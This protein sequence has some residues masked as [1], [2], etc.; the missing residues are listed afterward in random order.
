MTWH[1]L[2]AGS[3]GCLWAARLA[4]AGLPVTLLMRNQQRLDAYLQAGGLSLIENGQRFRYP[5]AAQTCD[6]SQPISRLLVA[7]K[8]YDAEA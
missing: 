3:L 1:V 6:H 8:A 7:C 5:V 4:R 2:G